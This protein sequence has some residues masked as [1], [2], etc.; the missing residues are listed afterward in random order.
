LIRERDP[1]AMDGR[2]SYLDHNATAPVRPEVAEAM[3]RALTLTGNASSVH[4][5]GRAA[6]AAVERAREEV[7][8]LVG[9]E[10]KNVVFTSGGTE[11][12]NAVLTPSLRRIGEEGAELLLAGAVEHVCVLE[13]HRF[14]AG[15]FETIPV[16]GQGV[17]DL[18][19]LAAQME[20]AG[21]ALVSIQ[22]ANNETGVIQP[23][24]EAAALVH[25]RGG[26][27]HVDA[28]QA[29]G[30]IPCDIKAI[31]ADVLT[32]SAHKLGGPK[33]VGAIVLAS[34]AI[35][36]GDRLIRGGGQE[37]GRRA[38]TENVAGIVGFGVAAALA[39]HSAPGVATGPETGTADG[40]ANGPAHGFASNAAMLRDMAEAR[41]RR[42]APDVVVFG[43]KVARLPNT[44]AFAIPGL[45]AETALIRFDLEGVAV[46]S[47][48]A[49][50]SGKVRRSHVLAAM[51]VEPA[52][53]EGAIRVSFGWDSTQEDVDRFM[54]ACEKLVAT[55]Y[56]RRATAA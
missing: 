20:G 36:I 27:L 24:A 23:V 45:R 17:V 44:L 46:S 4:A 11:A 40:T 9:A 14:P 26:L 12:A 7:A 41:L 16:D 30:K 18:S 51:G 29:A 48:S 50:S 38:G 43:D 54:A 55:L 22:A 32:L 21:R 47:G 6:R 49:C 1:K 35:E 8:A 13:S 39:G 56:E 53:A 2:R 37:R 5:E 28:V 3:A 15:A 10:P 42:L 33:G 34:D 19:W 52:L 31:G 25:A